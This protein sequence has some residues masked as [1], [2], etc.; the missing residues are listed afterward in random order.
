MQ[1]LLALLHKET[2][3]LSVHCRMTDSQPTDGITLVDLPP[4]CLLLVAEHL[5]DDLCSLFSAARAHSSLYSAA[6]QALSNVTLQLRPLEFPLEPFQLH[7]VN[8]SEH[9]TSLH[10]SAAPAHS[11]QAVVR[12]L[13]SLPQLI[14]VSF[15]SMTVQLQPADDNAGVLQS[16]SAV[17]KVRL[18]RCWV[19]GG[20]S[21]LQDALLDLRNLQD[22]ELCM[23]W[24]TA[25]VNTPIRQLSGVKLS[26]GFLQELSQWQLT[27]LYLFAVSFADSAA[28]SQLQ[29]LT[30]LQDLELGWQ[31]LHNADL[32]VTAL[33]LP[34][35][36]SLTSLRVDGFYTFTRVITP[37][38]APALPVDLSALAQ[39]TQLQRLT[40][41]HPQV[42][43]RS[44]LQPLQQLT[45]LKVFCLGENASAADCAA[46]TSSS[47][48]QHLEFHGLKFGLTVWQH[49]F[50][51]DRK[52][53]HLRALHT[54]KLCSGCRT[55]PTVAQ[56]AQLV[57]SCPAL[58]VLDLGEFGPREEVSAADYEVYSAQLSPL[59]QLT[60]L[61][62]LR[63][64]SAGTTAV[65]FLQSVSSL[66]SL[67]VGQV[68]A[69]N[70]VCVTQLTQ[71][72]RLVAQLQAQDGS[73]DV[74]EFNASKVSALLAVQDQYIVPSE[75]YNPCEHAMLS[76]CCCPASSYGN[77]PA[78]VLLF[79]LLTL[80]DH[81]SRSLTLADPT[82]RSQNCTY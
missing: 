65:S 73:T 70:L 47:K 37:G 18:Y 51:A 72:T 34:A 68:G 10:M 69:A 1:R 40:W 11:M 57:S 12:D 6:A 15:E 67:D 41:E 26:A 54:A 42:L 58:Q 2:L 21:A 3:L 28:A 14:D 13:P 81:T 78:T 49:L 4:P 77:L 80:A 25:D 29:Q 33:S 46:L 19:H 17:R 9:I 55:L 43:P 62:D 59:S 71:L 23:V 50:P 32:A 36:Y 74:L 56:A 52:L 20:V 75:G 48:L 60:C 63:L 44:V 30:A 35:S 7:I 64:P 61:Q 8:H 76:V 27:R 39:Q 5:K 79:H 82:S 53:P 38:A 22:L 31:V 24:D 45:Y 16:G 66:R